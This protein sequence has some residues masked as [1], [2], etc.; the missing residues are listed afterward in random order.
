MISGPSKR[1]FMIAVIMAGSLL[2]VGCSTT[3]SEDVATSTTST[4][5]VV[6]TP[7]QQAL[8]LEPAC[9]EAT[10]NGKRLYVEMAR[11]GIQISNGVLDDSASAQIASRIIDGIVSFC[12]DGEQLNG[13]IERLFIA[14]Y[15]H[16]VKKDPSALSGNYIHYSILCY[17]AKNTVSNF[18]TILEPLCERADNI[19]RNILQGLFVGDVSSLDSGM[20]SFL[21]ES[22]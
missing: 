13:S 1:V 15:D 14:S 2:A 18:P 20:E 7:T 8:E 3:S 16:T 4:S 9:L 10:E 12:G 5:L 11:S 22:P 6:P 21:E 19:T 17:R